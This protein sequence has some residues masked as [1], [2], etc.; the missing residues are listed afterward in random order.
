MSDREIFE[1]FDESQYEDEVRERWGDSPRYTESQAKWS[2]YSEEQKQAI[3]AEG[4][5]LAVR[6]V[7]M[8][9]NA[10]PDDAD[11]QTAI[12][13]YHAYINKYF[14]TC[15]VSFLRG[16]ADNWVQDPRFA[17]NYEAIRE[18]GAAFVGKAVHFFCDRNE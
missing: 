18:G 7:G 14:Y 10:S 5:D 13:E 15:D 11:V 16:L 8:D 2:S 6:M 12:G 9:P 3:K 1:G 4:G 17:I